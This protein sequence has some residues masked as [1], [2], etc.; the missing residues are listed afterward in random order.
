MLNINIFYNIKFFIISFIFI[1]ISFSHSCFAETD[2]DINA[3]IKK[4]AACHT[5][6]G[7]SIVPT[8]PKIAEQH[9]DYLL[10]QMLEYKKGKDGNR[11]EP[12]M[13]GMLQNLNENDMK[14]LADY[15]SKQILEKTK[16]KYNEAN[17]KIGK[18]LYL[19]GDKTNNIIACVGCH[20]ID[21]TGNKL[22]NFPNLKWQHK[23]YLILQL[24]KFK[25]HDRSNDINS[26]MQDITSNMSNEQIDALATYISCIE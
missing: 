22:A 13:F 9:S 26:I 18:K 14:E 21:A 12:T 2:A 1:V 15:F 8:W 10:K 23:E 16:T 4:C 5:L 19:Y 11:F 7:N 25:T 3:K 17:F 20:G 6:T 24:K